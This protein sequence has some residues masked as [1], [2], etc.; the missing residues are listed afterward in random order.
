ME[1]RLQ[2]LIEN[3]VQEKTTW[4]KATVIEP[5]RLQRSME[6]EGIESWRVQ[7]LMKKEGI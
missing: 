7:R 1:E 2:R 3:E 6:K 5:W 4:Q